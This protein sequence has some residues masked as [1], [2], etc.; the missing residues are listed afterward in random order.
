V[1]MR[2]NCSVSAV[3][4]MLRW[5]SRSAFETSTGRSGRPSGLYCAVPPVAFLA[6]TCRRV[7][8]A[9]SVPHS[10]PENRNFN[11]AR[12]RVLELAGHAYLFLAATLGPAGPYPLGYYSG[13]GSGSL[14][15]GMGSTD[16]AHRGTLCCDRGACIASHAVGAAF[17]PWR[18][19]PE[20]LK[21][22]HLVSVCC[23]CRPPAK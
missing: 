8:P 2:H 20:Q 10:R 1:V 13:G 18:V 9:R 6:G 23:C 16:A 22:I 7:S 14:R 21:T 19:I 17:G 15:S 11:T 3:C 5:F 12:V 4:S